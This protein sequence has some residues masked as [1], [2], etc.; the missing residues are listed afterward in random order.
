MNTNIQD[1]LFTVI[2]T[3]VKNR[4]NN[5]KFDRTI[6]GQVIGVVDSNNGLYKVLYND[7]TFVAKSNIDV[8]IGENVYVLIPENDFTN[9]KLILQ[10]NNNNNNV[11][12]NNDTSV[13]RA[14]KEEILKGLNL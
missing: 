2:D 9:T 5:A 8:N 1:D 10:R 14:T 12:T 11:I 6:G 13:E 7:I 3:I 4:I